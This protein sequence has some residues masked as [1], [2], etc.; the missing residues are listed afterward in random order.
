[1]NS[2]FCSAGHPIS[3]K[4]L[5]SPRNADQSCWIGPF[6]VF[7][8]CAVRLPLVSTKNDGEKRCFHLTAPLTASMS[9]NVVLASMP[10]V[11]APVVP[12]VPWKLVYSEPPLNLTKM[13]S[14]C[15]KR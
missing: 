4:G 13:L 8:L 15:E 5:G 6:T 10:L 1:M 2:R 9:R 14:D 3:P 12:P 7:V 11:G